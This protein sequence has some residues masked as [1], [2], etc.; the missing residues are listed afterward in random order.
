MSGQAVKTKRAFLPPPIDGLNL[1]APPSLMKDT[2]ARQLDNYYVYD[3]GIRER[4]SLAL[5]SS[6][7]FPAAPL[8]AIPIQNDP[9]NG[10]TDSCLVVSGGHV[11]YN[12]VAA[13]T[14]PTDLGAAS[15]ATECNWTIFNKYIFMF[16]PASAG[17]RYNVAAGT[18]GAMGFTGPAGNLIQGSPYKTR[19]YA[20]EN[21]TTLIWYGGVGAIT[22]ALTSFDV[23]QVLSDNANVFFVTGWTYNQGLTNDELF[24]IVSETG[25]VLVYA[26]DY[27][28][29]SN[30]SLVGRTRIPKPN[31]RSAWYK[32]GQEVYIR[33]KRGVVPLHQV[34]SGAPA[35]VDYYSV[36]R[37][38]GQ[39]LGDSTQPIAFNYLDPFLYFMD[40]GAQNLFVLNYERGAWS[41]FTF[42]FTLTQPMFAFNLLYLFDT[43][44][45]VYTIGDPYN[46]G[47]DPS[48]EFV[49]KSKYF[50]FGSTNQKTLRMVRAMVRLAADGS[51]TYPV[52]LGVRGAIAIDYSD[53]DVTNNELLRFA[54]SNTQTVTI[55][56]APSPGTPG[57]IFIAELAPPAMGT[58]FS[59]WLEKTVNN[60]P[61]K[62]VLGY[63]FIFDDGGVY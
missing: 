44:G 8:A 18:I 40:A 55:G 36:S 32:L 39:Y 20:V 27:P 53:Y 13:F 6:Y 52:A 25:E 43:N 61:P 37:N 62:E 11:Y 5:K 24:V 4:Q 63:E 57:D 60:A 45:A 17:S 38:L 35:D 47:V 19:L 30:W 15:I 42:G 1:I 28:G 2:E 21:N 7:S 12:N 31:G 23:S 14:A 26:G 48:Y 34:F 50:D 10:N 22:G 9:R 54:D 49:S 29:A 3:W 46:T 51:G 56:M 41:R 59:L 33:T 58:R 16:T